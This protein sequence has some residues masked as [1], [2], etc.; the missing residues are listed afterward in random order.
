MNRTEKRS[1]KETSIK[2][3][4]L[5]GIMLFAFTALPLS[6]FPANAA[7]SYIEEDIVIEVPS[8]Y[9]FVPSTW[10][11]VIIARDIYVGGKI[12]I[13]ATL[14]LQSNTSVFFLSNHYA[15]TIPVLT[16]FT[17]APGESF[18]GTFTVGY[19]STPSN[20]TALHAPY[21]RPYT[22]CSSEGNAEGYSIN[23]VSTGIALHCQPVDLDKNATIR[24][25]FQIIDR[26]SVQEWGITSYFGIAFVLLLMVTWRIAKRKV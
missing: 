19:S 9:P 6:V 26:N 7:G 25:G 15:N 8:D 22:K 16:N 14:L 21:L 18:S 23:T 4:V 12:F 13:N 24:W 20:S 10:Y 5:F 17:L 1:R 11:Q 3:Y 2:S